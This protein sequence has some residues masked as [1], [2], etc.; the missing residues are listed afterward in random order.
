MHVKHLVAA[1]AI[2]ASTGSVLAQEFVDPA[3]NFVSARSRA[4]VIAELKQAQ[5]DGTDLVLESNYPVVRV[6]GTPKT[7][8]EVLAELKQAQNDGSN[9]ATE[10]TYP[11]IPAAMV[12]R[13]RSEVRAERD[14]YLKAHPFGEIDTRY[15]S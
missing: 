1:F 6:T 5:A 14:A 8:T 10:V 2:L 15:G 4:E 12:S 9:Y 3:A 11:I 7:R 13:S